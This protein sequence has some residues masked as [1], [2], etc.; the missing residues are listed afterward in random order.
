MPKS[1]QR[2]KSSYLVGNELDI[3]LVFVLT[4]HTPC[5]SKSCIKRKID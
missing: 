2:K 1:S 4:R 5:I 3:N